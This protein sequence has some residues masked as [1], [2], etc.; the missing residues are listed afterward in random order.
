MNEASKRVDK[1][2]YGK[3]YLVGAGPGD[4]D[5]LTVKAAKAIQSADVIVYDNLVSK[6]IRNTFPSQ[7]EAI[8][9]GKMKGQHSRSQDEINE[10]MAH[11]ATDGRNVCRVKGGDAFIF[12]RGG[13]EMLFL[14]RKG[15]QVQV[16]PGITAASGCTAYAG[17]PLTHRGLAQGCTFITAHAN[18]DLEIE[19]RSLAKLNQ[20]IVVY[21]GLSKTRLITEELISA[22]LNRETPV[23]IIENGC[24]AKQRNIVGKLYQLTDLKE[25]FD[26]LS[27]SLI[28]I[29]Q[30][31]DVYDE[32][33]WLSWLSGSHCFS[34]YKAPA[35]INCCAPVTT[36]PKSA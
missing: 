7:V 24:T 9:V 4:P 11:L 16:I 20:T 19:W 29:G 31:V 35:Y 22:G 23:A 1:T 17:I 6:E 8:Y 3:A 27:P 30:V 13:E 12:G 26:L 34:E 36:L 2:I 33:N 25:E 18:T 32:L 15:I 5:L 21:M 14:S 28:V 10:L